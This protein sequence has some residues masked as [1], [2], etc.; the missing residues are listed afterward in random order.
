MTWPFKKQSP[1]TS[2]E[3]DKVLKRLSE[4]QAQI[5]DLEVKVNKHYAELHSLR[6]KVYKEKATEE[7]PPPIDSNTRFSPFG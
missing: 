2:D 6:G 3:Y 7:E 1:L 4:M 5:A